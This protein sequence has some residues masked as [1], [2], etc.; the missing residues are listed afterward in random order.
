MKKLKLELPEQVVCSW[1]TLQ[2][3]VTIVFLLLHLLA[4]GVCIPYLFSWSGVGVMVVGI[5]LFSILGINLCYHRLLTHRSFKVHRWLERVLTLLAFCNL[6]G[7]SR[8][9]VGAHRVHHQHT[10]ERPDPH[11]PLVKFLWGHIGWMLFKNPTIDDPDKLNPNVS[12]LLKDPFHQWFSA[13]KRWLMVAIT[14]ALVIF[15]LGALYGGLRYSEPLQFGLSWLFWGVFFRIV[16]VWHV[17][18]SINSVTHLAGYRTYRSA[19]CSGNVWWIMFFTAGESWHNNHHADQN[20][21]SNWHRWWEFDLTY[22][23]IWTLEKIGLAWDVKRPRFDR[24][25]ARVV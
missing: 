19:E 18:W 7:S 22:C 23:I 3:P 11:S 24:I 25:K 2:W 6:E 10:D 9:W 14:H 12:D 21:A 1:Q 8:K 20:S 4:F 15:G 5:F 17:T 13:K 16:L